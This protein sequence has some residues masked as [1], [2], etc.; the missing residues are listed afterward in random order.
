[1]SSF[2]FSLAASFRGIAAA[3][4]SPVTLLACIIIVPAGVAFTVVSYVLRKDRQYQEEE[5][6]IANG[7]E[8]DLRARSQYYNIVENPAPRPLEEELVQM[9][10]LVKYTTSPSNISCSSS[11][12]DSSSAILGG[13]CESCVVCLS[14]FEEEELVKMLPPC[15]HS[16]HVPCIDRWF[17]THSTCP[18]CRRKVTI[19]IE[20]APA[21]AADH[22]H[23]QQQQQG[24]LLPPPLKSNSSADPSSSS[25]SA[26]NIVVVINVQD[27]HHSVVINV[28]DQHHSDNWTL[29][30]V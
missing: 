12:H 6:E 24:T 20:Q 11:S 4:V 16:F 27:P 22:H 10:P 13:D 15:Q 1:M 25:H 19:D 28:Q 29:I 17:Q 2:L 7:G 9:I 23:Q 5:E 30:S 18:L 21:A 8:T 26:C 3:Y 14:Q